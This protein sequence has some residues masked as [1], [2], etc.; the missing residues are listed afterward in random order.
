MIRKFI[1]TGGVIACFILLSCEPEEISSSRFF[2]NIDVEVVKIGPNGDAIV[3]MVDDT[4][5]VGQIDG[6]LAH[7]IHMQLHDVGDVLH[8]EY[9][10]K[11]RFIRKT[12]DRYIFSE[13]DSVA[14]E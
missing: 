10:S 14:A 1:H 3:R 7:N 4:T 9:I 8:F 11:K 6:D 5:I 13:Q 2:K 12:K